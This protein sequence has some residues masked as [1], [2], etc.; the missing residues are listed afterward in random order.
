[1]GSGTYVVGSQVGFDG[2]RDGTVNFDEDTFTELLTS[3]FAGL[4]NFLL[5]DGEDGYLDRID[6]A[7]GTVT[8]TQ[9]VIENATTNLDANIDDIDDTIERYE[10]R[11]EVVEAGLRRQFTAMETLL[12]QLNSQ[13]SFLATQL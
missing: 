9:G 12:A 4:Q 8:D 5:G 2:T 1:M 3:D 13:S 6:G 7:I 10:R 11:M